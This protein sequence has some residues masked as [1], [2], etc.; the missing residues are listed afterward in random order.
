MKNMRFFSK[1]N[2]AI[3][4][5]MVSTDFKLRYQGSVLGYLWSLMRP[6]FTFLV[7]YLVF[8]VLFKVGDQI[9]HFAVYLLLGIVIWTFFLEVTTN[10]LN[11]I[12][13]RGELLRKISIPRYLLVVSV[14]VSALINL[15]LNLVVVFVF[16]LINQVEFSWTAVL[17]PV[18][19]LEMYVF[20]LAIAFIFSALYV[21]Y[22]DMSHIWEIIT[23]AAFYATPI[24]YPL[25]KAPEQLQKII[26]LSPVAQ[27][28]QDARYLFVTHATPTS[29]SVLGRYSLIPPCIVLIMSLAA[30]FY[31]KKAQRSFAEDL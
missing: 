13:S 8:V 25:T 3:L 26:M 5:E 18:V 24:V 12:V 7:M 6:M 9:P 14:S 16:A 17:L 23:Q 10:G 15:L 30:F 31:F 2:R 27:V 21:K 22:R 28:I 20:A 4:R 19:L 11:A 1:R 29:W